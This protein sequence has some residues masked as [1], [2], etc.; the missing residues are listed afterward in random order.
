MPAAICGGRARLSGPVQHGAGMNTALPQRVLRS[1]HHRASLRINAASS[2]C[3]FWNR[4]Q[5]AEVE[6]DRCFIER[7][8]TVPVTQVAYFLVPCEK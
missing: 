7:Y 8:E 4:G 6:G 5:D 1:G 2:R 3:E